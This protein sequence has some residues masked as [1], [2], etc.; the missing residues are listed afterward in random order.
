MDNCLGEINKINLSYMPSYN[1][2]TSS[3]TPK[4]PISHEKRSSSTKEQNLLIFS[5]QAS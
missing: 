3:I 5:N 2:S 4:S 1:L